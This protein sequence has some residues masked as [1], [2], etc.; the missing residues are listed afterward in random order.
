MEPCL[1]YGR[2]VT[3]NASYCNALHESLAPSACYTESPLNQSMR[4][5]TI[6]FTFLM[7][8]WLSPIQGAS[9]Q[10]PEP[11]VNPH[12]S[13]V[14][15]HVILERDGVETRLEHNMPIA[16]GDRVRSTTGRA[17]L[18]LSPGVVHLDR[19]T[20]LELESDVSWRLAAGR[21]HIVT[22]VT[23]GHSAGVAVGRR[24][25]IGVGDEFAIL[26]TPGEYDIRHA[27]DGWLI[28]VSRGAATL[29]AESGCVGVRAGERLRVSAGAWPQPTRL[30]DQRR[31]TTSSWCGCRAGLLCG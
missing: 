15:G 6:C 12:A 9:A 21:V 16:V 31:R 28:D 23:P 25:R 26:D 29:H 13:L 18:L 19:H 3:T 27:H 7:V 1:Q 2:Y 24:W 20:I 14:S 8:G 17:E 22:R 5:T 30:H 4:L 11:A 10:S